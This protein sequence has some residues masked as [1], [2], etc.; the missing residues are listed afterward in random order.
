MRYVLWPC[1]FSLPHVFDLK[2]PHMPSSPPPPPPK[3]Y[4]LLTNM[5]G[6]ETASPI[7]IRNVPDSNHGWGFFVIFLSLFRKKKLTSHPLMFIRYVRALRCL[8]SWY[9]VVKWPDKQ[10][11]NKRYC[12]RMIKLDIHNGFCVV[13]WMSHVDEIPTLFKSSW[14]WGSFSHLSRVRPKENI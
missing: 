1:F 8:R 7:R 10:K 6:M 3:E 5:V 12:L 13:W 2:W 14:W 11:A 9:V 4:S